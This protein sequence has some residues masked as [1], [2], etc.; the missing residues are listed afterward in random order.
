MGIGGSLFFSLK[1][2]KGI[3]KLEILRYKIFWFGLAVKILLS[4]FFAGSLLKN[5]FIPF[6]TYFF[7][8]GF[9]NP[10]ESF[11]DVGALDAFPYPP[12]MLYVLGVLGGFISDISPFFI[13]IPL[14][15]AD[16][17][18]LLILGRLLKS[19][20]IK[21]LQYYWLSPVLIYIT[22]IHGQFDVVP[23]MFLLASSYLLF[24][25][26]RIREK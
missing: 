25:C 11:F 10:Y 7:K 2:K 26:N 4:F 23:I 19:K 13:R 5:S 18:I 24:I 22:Y 16:V 17:L 6:V 14:L 20:E 3:F 8:S 1:D 21:L 12:F 9:A 15:L